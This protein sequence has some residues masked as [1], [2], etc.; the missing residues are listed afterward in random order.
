MSLTE[1]FYNHLSIFDVSLALL[2]LFLVCCLREKLTN[3]HGPMLWPVFGIT[4]EF[5]FHIN[6]VYGWVTKS[7]KNGRGTFLH[8]GI[9][10]DGSYGAVTCVPANVEYMLKTNFKNFPKGSFYKH[11]FSDLLEDGIFNTDDASWKEQRRIILT[12]MHSTKFMEHSFQTIHHLVKKK[13]LKVMESF[14]RSQK[15]FDLQDV[16]LR[17]TFDIICTAGLG[18]DPETLAADLPKVPFAKA[19]EEATESTL[20]RFMIPPFIWRTMKFLDIGYERSLRKAIEVVHGFVNKM[21][22]DRISKIKEEETLDNRFDVLTR[23]VQIES[24]RKG[25]E[26]DPSTIRFFRQ[27]CTSFILAGRDTSS[28]A[29]SW[30]FW[31]IQKHPQVENKIISEIKEILRQRGDT[32]TCKNESLFTVRELN[33]MV[34]LQAALSETLRLYPPIPM[35][36]KQAVEDDVFPDGTFIRKGSRIYFSIYAMGRMESVWGKDCEMF[37]P[38]R[39]INQAGQFV[40]IEQFKFVVFNAGPRLCIGKTFAFLQMK[41]IAASLLWRYSIKVVQDHVVVP[42]FTTNFYMKYGLKVNIKPRSLEEKK[43]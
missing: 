41:M 3:K 18:D 7:L 20:F 27:F 5:F 28:V 22:V 8:R 6:D 17:L 24:Q 13:L 37:R 25:N 1:R 9:W 42:R 14:A 34:Y 29:V 43:I 40:N 11:R 23:I 30:F 39:W 4:P 10:L 12:E 38:E 26:I 35:E 36:M 21:I 16:L 19:F 15:A 32:P 31:V 33:N 2:G